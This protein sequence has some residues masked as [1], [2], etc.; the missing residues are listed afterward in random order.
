MITEH[1]DA[2]LNRN[3]EVVLR[4]MRLMDGAPS[5]LDALDEVLAPD[6][7]LQLGPPTSTE[8]RQRTSSERS[9]QRFPT[10]RIRPRRY[11]PLVTGS[12]FDNEPRDP[13]R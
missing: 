1:A 4:F 6:L 9:T 2:D 10:T 11:S 13:Q 3:K 5:D 12:S 8:P 7:R